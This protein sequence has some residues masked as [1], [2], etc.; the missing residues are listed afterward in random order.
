M[1]IRCNFPDISYLSEAQKN[2]F[3]LFHLVNMVG[4]SNKMH[5]KP[6]ILSL[7]L[8]SRA[9]TYDPLF[10]LTHFYATIC[11]NNCRLGIHVIR[12]VC[13]SSDDLE[14]LLY[15][16]MIKN[17]CKCSL[18]CSNSASYFDQEKEHEN[19]KNPICTFTVSISTMEIIS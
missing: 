8:N 14:T 12:I 2:N 19:N 4:I 9:L 7:F 15:F 3:K 16:L 10:Y 13:I 1:K 11:G 5:H 17:A 6:C 18:Y